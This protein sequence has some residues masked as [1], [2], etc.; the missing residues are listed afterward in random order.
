[1]VTGQSLLNKFDTIE[2][3]KYVET[4]Q[5]SPLHCHHPPPVFIYPLSNWTLLVEH[6]LGLMLF[7][8]A[9]KIL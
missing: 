7:A 2:C 3:R 1:M 5:P 9:T 6:V 8:R 4:L